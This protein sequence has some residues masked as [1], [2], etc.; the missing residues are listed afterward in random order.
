MGQDLQEEEIQMINNQFWELYDRDP[1][2][3]Q[4]LTGDPSHFSVQEKFSILNAYAQGQGVSG[5]MEQYQNEEEDEAYAEE[6]A[7]LIL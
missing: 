1:E 4:A 6:Q 7:K 3:R 2:L 5:M